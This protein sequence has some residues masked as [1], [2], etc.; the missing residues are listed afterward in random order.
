LST[1]WA[2]TLFSAAVLSRKVSWAWWCEPPMTC[3]AAL[4]TST[5]TIASQAE[6]TRLGVSGQ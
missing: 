1:V 4:S 3:M 2:S 6:T 5:S